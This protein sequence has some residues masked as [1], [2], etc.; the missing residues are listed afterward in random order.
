MAFCE[1]LLSVGEAAAFNEI[2]LLKQAGFDEWNHQE[3]ASSSQ[4][5]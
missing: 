5:A 3:I 2:Y 4:R 1:Y